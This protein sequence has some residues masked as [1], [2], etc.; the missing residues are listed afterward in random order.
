MAWRL[1][2]SYP[3]VYGS[4]G[5]VREARVV[6]AREMDISERAARQQLAFYLQMWVD[7]D[8]ENRHVQQRDGLNAWL[9]ER[10]AGCACVVCADWAPKSLEQ[11]GEAREW[12][13]YGGRDVHPG[14]YAR[15]KRLD[16]PATRAKAPVWRVVD[17][18]LDDRGQV[19]QG[20]APTV[21]SEHFTKAEAQRGL[22]AAC[23]RWRN[24]GTKT[25]RRHSDDSYMLRWARRDYALMMIER[26]P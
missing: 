25:A 3:K 8:P 9:L 18:V 2:H 23:N 11:T 26:V 6:E 21:W 22:T 10:P 24:G 13:W 15:L 5:I 17:R 19:E 16:A 20:C 4:G 14:S 12:W 1:R 7:A